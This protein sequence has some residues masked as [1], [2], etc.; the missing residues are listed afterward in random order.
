ML[1]ASAFS[2]FPSMVYQDLVQSGVE[3]CL[4]AFV[5]GAEKKRDFVLYEYGLECQYEGWGR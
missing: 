4:G 1:R 5:G 2:C 3:E